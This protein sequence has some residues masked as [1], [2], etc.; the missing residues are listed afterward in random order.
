MKYPESEF[1]LYILHE[2]QP[3]QQ[4]LSLQE[5]QA[6]FIAEFEDTE[7]K[8]QQIAA[9]HGSASLMT[10]QELKAKAASLLQCIIAGP[11][12]ATGQGNKHPLDRDSRI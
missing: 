3:K 4:R 9:S 10:G 1:F 7:Y 12:T 11:Q 8:L 6:K 2:L 5:L